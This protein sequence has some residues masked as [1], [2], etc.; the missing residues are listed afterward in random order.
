MPD[1]CHESTSS[2]VWS[3]R[4]DQG[5]PDNTRCAGRRHCGRRCDPSPATASG[6]G[7]CVPAAR[8]PPR[9]LRAARSGRGCRRRAAPVVEVAGDQQRRVGRDLASIRSHSASICRWRC[10]SRRPRCTQTT[11]I[12]TDCQA[13]PG[14]T[15][16][17]RAASALAIDTSWLRKRAIGNLDSTAMP[18]YH[19]KHRIAA[20]GELRPK[21]VC[22]D[23]VV[24]SVGH[25][26][27]VGTAARGRPPLQAHHIRR[28]GSMALAIHRG[29]ARAHSSSW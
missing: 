14:R 16:A 11:W 27:C 26:A 28:H 13:R 20:I 25:D 6:P 9:T 3:D 29:S 17:C 5:R 1:S 2:A 8:S 10:D 24:R 15:T 7:R 12:C 21:G 23:L 18:R 22:D 4:C 19:R